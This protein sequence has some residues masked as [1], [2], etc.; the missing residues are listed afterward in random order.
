VTPDELSVYLNMP[1]EELENLLRI[2][3]ETIELADRAE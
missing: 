3:G 2:A 1:P